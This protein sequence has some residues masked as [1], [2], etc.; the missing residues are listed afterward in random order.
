MKL[1]K[2]AR[3]IRRDLAA[4][5]KKAAALGLMVLVA[6]YFW[7]PLVWGWIKSA[8]GDAKPVVAASEVILE[9]EPADPAKSVRKQGRVFSWEKVRRK[10][11]ADPHMTPALYDATWS[12]PFRPDRSPAAGPATARAPTASSQVDP[13]ALGM[14]VTSVAIGPQHRT[15]I[16]NGEK[17]REGEL[18]PLMGANRQ[19]VAGIEF[20][21]VHV[22]FH[23]VQ[24]EYQAVTFTLELSR[25]R[26]APGDSISPTP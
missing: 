25:P 3:Q 13:A 17:Y 23:E 15:A 19:P 18:V 9:D 5:P 7:A 4:S 8:K 6:L 16:I 10:V 26:L 12:D 20:R 1:D 11:V 21:L 14:K 22:G 2:L 24:L